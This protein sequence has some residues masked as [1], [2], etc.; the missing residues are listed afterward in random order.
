MSDYIYNIDVITNELNQKGYSFL[1]TIKPVLEAN[2]IYEKY[3]EENNLGTYVEALDTHKLLIDLLDLQKLF[4]ALHT[5]AEQTC[6]KK[7]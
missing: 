1:P 4:S 3:L 6:R 2:L 7:Y 5:L